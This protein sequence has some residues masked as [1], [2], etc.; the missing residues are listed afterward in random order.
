MRDVAFLN[1]CLVDGEVEGRHRR[2][3]ARQRAVA[4]ALCFEATIVL[5]LA[6]WP[7]LTPGTLPE[8][9]LLARVPYRSFVTPLRPARPAT[10]NAQHQTAIPLPTFSPSRIP[11]HIS[12]PATT[13]IESVNVPPI[14]P[15]GPGIPGSGG[16]LDGL[17]SG[18]SPVP[19]PA[20]P[21]VRVIH[22]SEGVQ[23][24][25]LIS[26]VLPAYPEIAR[27]AR[28]SGTVELMVLVGRDGSVISVQVLSGSPLL[29]SSAKNAVEQWRYR[30]AVLDGQAVEVE[31]RVTVNFVLN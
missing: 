6:L 31:A 14:G 8:S 23:E 24:T 17:G 2:R 29:A 28:I 21:A 19:P 12:Q 25:Q 16:F 1:E 4:V 7:L 5:G 9:V 15:S 22:R 26:R 13:S 27:A 20:R 30:P 10:S 11:P 18:P 3:S